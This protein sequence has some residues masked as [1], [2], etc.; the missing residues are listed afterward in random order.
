[1]LI[2]VAGA[3][4]SRRRRGRTT[5]GNCGSTVLGTGVSATEELSNSIHEAH[6]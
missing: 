3:I 2:G 6:A 1:V 4:V 5:C